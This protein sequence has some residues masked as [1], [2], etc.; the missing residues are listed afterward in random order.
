VLTVALAVRR[1]GP[2]PWALALLGA[3]YAVYLETSHPSLAV[4]S[5]FAGGFI[6]AAELAFRALEPVSIKDEP[7]LVVRRFGRAFT[8]AVAAGVLGGLL[9]EFSNVPVARGLQ[10]EALGVVA[11]V[12]TLAAVAWLAH[13]RG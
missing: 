1:A 8:T 10:V 5:V 3:A 9:L 2:V 13:S 11:A 12:A 4:G 6:L 7:S